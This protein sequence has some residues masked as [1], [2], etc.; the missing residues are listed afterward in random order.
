[1]VI[2]II[3]AVLVGFTPLF[4][5]CST[6]SAPA[7]QAAPAVSDED[8][9]RD[10]LEQE[11]D[12]ISTWDGAKLAALTCAE[13]RDQAGSF[14]DMAPP[15][16]SFQIPGIETVTP[17]ALAEQIVVGFPGATDESALAA[18][19]AVLSNDQVAYQTAMTEVMQQSTTIKLEKVDNIKVDG[20]TATADLTLSLTVAGREAPS[21]DRGV[22]LIREDGKWLDCTPPSE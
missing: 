8:Q 18:A 22:T 16:S 17:E 11:G 4:A 1:M 19:E 9:I 10:V 12:A 14:E 5:G 21:E 20:D 7:P 3:G 6:A 13:Y 15:M 2:R